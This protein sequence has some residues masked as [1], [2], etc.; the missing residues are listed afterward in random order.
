MADDD[1]VTNTVRTAGVDGADLRILVENSEYWLRNNGDLAMLEVTIA[2][3]RERW[4]AAR[5]AILTDSPSLLRAYF[6]AAEGITVVDSDP[7]A[8]PAAIEG[9]V[10]GRGPAVVGPFALGWLRLRAFLPQKVRGARNRLHRAADRVV[11]RTPT[12]YNTVPKRPHH[13]SRRAAAE[14]SLLLALGGGY[15]TDADATQTRRVLDL[16]DHAADH[17]VP[18]A[19]VGQGLGPLESPELRARAKEVLPR[20]GF[21]AMREA[22]RGPDLL[23]ELGVDDAN[24]MVTGDDAIE[25]AYRV[26]RNEIGDN[27]GFCLRVAGYAPVSDHAQRVVGETVRSMAHE[28]GTRIA[29][30][31]IAEY[32]SQD[33]RSTLPVLRDADNV[34][35]PPGRFARPSAIAR[36][37]GTCRIVVTGAYHLAVFALSQGIPVVALSSTKYYDD[38]FYG[39]SE[40]FGCGLWMVSL[41]DDRLA[42]SL[43]TAIRTAWYEAEPLRE[44]LRKRAAEQIQLSRAGFDRIFSVV[45]GRAP[46]REV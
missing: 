22:R 14:A 2:R 19:L 45:E 1:A 20:V 30:V 27:I 7:W 8:R 28:F 10:A 44:P 25:L 23:R 40:M 17:H 31:V 24:A 6:P 13:G 34:V 15:L 39:L 41:D 42:E 21:I 37:A 29:P 33:R 4:P 18:V 26:R 32:R 35:P 12:T 3:L 5:I 16:I 9:F 11:G 36:Q 43:D 46:S 38:K